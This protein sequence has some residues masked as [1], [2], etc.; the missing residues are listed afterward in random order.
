MPSFIQ[1][2]DWLDYQ[3]KYAKAINMNKTPDKRWVH[4]E[5]KRG[6]YDKKSNVVC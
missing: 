2:N 4:F 5:I 1:R 3:P 6:L